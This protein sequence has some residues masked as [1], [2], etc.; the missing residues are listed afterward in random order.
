MK[1][2]ITALIQGW[3]KIDPVKRAELIM[4]ATQTIIALAMFAI[5]VFTG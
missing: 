1:H 3:Q 5:V 2:S 4:L